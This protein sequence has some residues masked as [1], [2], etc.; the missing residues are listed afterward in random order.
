MFNKPAG[1]QGLYNFHKYWGKKPSEL[2]RDLVTCLSP[3]GGLILDPFVGYGAIARE[4]V[5]AGRNFI[6]IDINPIAIRLSKLIVDPPS[7]E[8]LRLGLSQIQ[9]KVRAQIDETYIIE[10]IGEAASHYLWNDND[11]I[12]VWRKVARHKRIEL[13]PTD[14]DICLSQSFASYKSK[15]IRPLS[16]FDNSR[17]NCTRDMSI[18]DLLTGRAQY[19]ID[20]IYSCINDFDDDLR[21]AFSLILT[22]A[23]GQMSQMVF[24]ITGRGKTSGAESKKI[25]VGSWVIGYWRPRLHFEVNGWN[26][27][28]RRARRLVKAVEQIPNNSELFSDMNNKIGSTT[29]LCSD[30]ESALRE[31]DANIVDLIITDPPHT[32]RIPYLELSEFWNS[33]LNETVDYDREIVVSNASVRKMHP[34]VYK[35]RLKRVF[36]ECGRVLKNGCLLVVLFNARDDDSWNI[37]K[38]CVLK[39]S[40]GAVFKFSGHFN[41]EYSA[42]SVVQDNRPGALKQDFGLV[43]RKG[44]ATKNKVCGVEA[45]SQ[46]PG[47]S[48]S[49]PREDA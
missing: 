42:G 31:I 20:L 10:R 2:M 1:Y 38:D 43:F 40:D 47:W 49:W 29:L 41:C 13:S 27:F 44:T 12:S 37:I 28:E 36:E 25:E 4:T 16:L 19:N 46:L 14:A 32:D 48:E 22:S 18:S 5:L 21:E 35:E 9:N 23:A 24:A 11:L 26:C 3:Q 8:R 7:A 15:F 34:G 6:G 33:I 17:I 45:L 39:N 30:C